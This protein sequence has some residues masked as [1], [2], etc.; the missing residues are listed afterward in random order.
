MK[1]I[2]GK[3]VYENYEEMLDPQHTAVLVID[4][5]KEGV[6]PN[7]YFGRKGADVSIVARIVPPLAEFLTAARSAGVKV[8]YVNQITLLDGKGDSPAW[9]HLKEHAYKL[10]PPALGLEDDYM[11]QGTEG[12]RVVPELAPEPEDLVVEKNRASGFVNTPLNLL[13][14]S[15]G[16]E[17]VVITGE[18]SYGCAL[19]TLMDATCYDYYT[20]V[21][22]DLIAGPNKALH[23]A[24]LQ[25]IRARY[26]CLCSSE[27]V[28]I[29]QERRG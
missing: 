7:G 15:N 29:W 17:T 13:L 22:E 26:D 20:V 5:Q 18:S 16:V 23:E 25:L 12:Q 10:V 19:N 3:Q 9:L 21:T 8:V 11:M 1:T 28:R 14:R 24:A 2:K 4:M 6:D 27:I